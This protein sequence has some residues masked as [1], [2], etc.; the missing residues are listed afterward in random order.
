MFKAARVDPV[1]H[2]LID[3]G[4]RRQVMRQQNQ[5]APMRP[6]FDDV[7]HAIEDLAQMMPP[8]TRRFGQQRQI[9]QIGRGEGPF[10]VAH[11]S[12]VTTPLAWKAG[13]S[14]D[15]ASLRDAPRG[16]VVGER[17]PAVRADHLC[18]GG[19]PVMP[20]T[21]EYS[22]QMFKHQTGG[23]IRRLTA[24]LL[25]PPCLKAGALSRKVG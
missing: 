11:I 19:A 8:W 13:A 10:F 15:L 17:Y 5:H 12:G 14:R 23:T 1:T 18:A 3:H 2:L 25:S 20:F 4:P 7:T 6:G 24:T 21:G 9:R 22:K 16:T